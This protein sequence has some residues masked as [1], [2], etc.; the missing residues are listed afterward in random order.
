MCKTLQKYLI[1]Y[2]A[3]PI[4]EKSLNIYSSLEKTNGI[5]N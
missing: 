5:Q 4:Y 3:D 1:Q 2:Q